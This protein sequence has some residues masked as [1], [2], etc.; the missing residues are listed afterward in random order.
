M[1]LDVKTPACVLR[2]VYVL[3]FPILSLLRR[4]LVPY[5]SWYKNPPPPPLR[6]LRALALLA[7]C[8][9]ATTIEYYGPTQKLVPSE[10]EKKNETMGSSQDF[11]C[12]HVLLN[13]LF[14]KKL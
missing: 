7:L 14:S 4:G 11:F 6:T 13:V 3:S 10:R 8:V 5:T 9:R 12:P 1:C 2:V